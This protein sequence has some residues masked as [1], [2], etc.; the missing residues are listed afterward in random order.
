[1][2]RSEYKK[3]VSELKSQLKK[4]SKEIREMKAQRKGSYGGFV[5]GLD[6]MRYD[7]RHYHIVY[8]EVRGREREDIEQPRI[9]NFAT[10]NLALASF[11]LVDNLPCAP[12]NCS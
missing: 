2:T 3:M 1:M 6:R 12:Y 5:S 10:P 9:D 8:C 4:W 11:S 7:A